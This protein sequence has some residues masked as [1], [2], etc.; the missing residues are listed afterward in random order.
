[1][2][3]DEVSSRTTGLVVVAISAGHG[4]RDQVEARR[5]TQVTK[6]GKSCIHIVYHR[7]N[8]LDRDKV[9]KWNS[10]SWYRMKPYYGDM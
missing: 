3:E 8:T 9:Y 2:G 6:N 7:V 5:E 4:R 1:M 10:N